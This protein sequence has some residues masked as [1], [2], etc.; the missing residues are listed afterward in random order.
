MYAWRDARWAR[1]T[2]HFFF[3]EAVFLLLPGGRGIKEGIGG[4][5]MGE[6]RPGIKQQRG[7]E[8]LCGGVRSVRN[9][10]LTGWF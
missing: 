9:S 4:R 7:S 3:L 5:R 1:P 10:Q 8:G 6:N 2:L